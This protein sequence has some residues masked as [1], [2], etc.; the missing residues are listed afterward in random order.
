MNPDDSPQIFNGASNSRR[1]GCDKN[2]SRHFKHRFRI[3]V[4]VNWTFFPGRDPR[5]VDKRKKKQDRQHN[6]KPLPPKLPP[7][8]PSPHSLTFK[9]PGDDVI[10]VEFISLTH[11][12]GLVVVDN[13]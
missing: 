7:S 4:S 13:R 11:C 5:T 6:N 3:S 10:N 9:Q 12:K 8:Y 2:I 1:M